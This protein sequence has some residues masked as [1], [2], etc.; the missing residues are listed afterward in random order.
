MKPIGRSFIESYYDGHVVLH[1]YIRGIQ[2]SYV[3]YKSEIW[4][5]EFHT[6][7]YDLGEPNSI[8][9]IQGYIKYMHQEMIKICS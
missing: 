3:G 1:V 9:E 7:K 8:Q 5:C 2:Y 4:N 6:T